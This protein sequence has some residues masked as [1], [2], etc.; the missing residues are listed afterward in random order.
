[1]S[2]LLAVPFYKT[3]PFLFL[4]LQKSLSEHFWLFLAA[5]F[6]LCAAIMVIP[7]LCMGAIFPTV[8]R[9]YTQGL[10]KLGRRIGNIYFFN[11][12]GGIAGSF[13]G[14]FVMIPIL[15]VQPSILLT[16][17]L[18]ITL[19]VLV[20]VISPVSPIKRFGSAAAVTIVFVAGLYNVPTWNSMIMT[21]G[22]YVNPIGNKALQAL[23]ETGAFGEL[24][25]Y[26]EGLNATITVRREADGRTISY[27]SNGK[28][29]AKTVDSKPGKAWSLL[30]H[31]PM[32]LSDRPESALL[33]G[34]GSGITL[35]SMEQYPLKEIDVVEIEP[36]VVEAAHYFDAANNNALDDP[37]VTMHTTDGRN[38]LLTGRKRYDVIVSAVSD[39][40][41]TG[42]SNLFTEEYFME[43]R[44][45]LSDNGVVAL[46]FQNYRISTNDLKIGLNT[47]ASVFPQVSLWVH[48]AQTSDMIVIGTNHPRN[49]DMN[50]LDGKMNQERV[51]RDLARIEM[52]TPYDVL[53]LFLMG[54]DDIRKYIGGVPVNIDDKPILEF[55]LP[56]L[57]HTNLLSGANDR[58]IDIVANAQDFLPPT[59]PPE[60]EEEFYFRLG[61]TYASYAF[62]TEQAIKLFERV[63]ELNPENRRAAQYLLLLRRAARQQGSDSE[64]S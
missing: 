52:S 39:P 58:V 2:A 12:A 32:L 3:L 61:A 17:A 33:V 54:N 13:I 62:R 51:R 6:L 23:Q 1:M 34:I 9:I 50:A 56:K 57:L 41:I 31:L 24:L 16:A 11:T 44:N 49:F 10:D 21:M 53:N 30:G 55:A 28:Y 36:A 46:W 18:S 40:W 38:F 37:R 7:T 8:G 15:G 64:A 4:S 26:R 29:E 20:L 35:G 5:Q 47:F 27:Q 48:H 63:L 25:F 19:G 22:T 59:L 45:R 43:V 14:G 60:N 42:V